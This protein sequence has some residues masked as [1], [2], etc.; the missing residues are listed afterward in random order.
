MLINFK[1]MS[2]RSIVVRCLPLLNKVMHRV[3]HNNWG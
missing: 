1:A 2:G 3:A